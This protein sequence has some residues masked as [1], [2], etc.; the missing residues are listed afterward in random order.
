MINL[1]KM[2]LKLKKLKE[3]KLSNDFLILE[4]KKLRE[5]INETIQSEDIFA[6]GFS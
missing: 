5:L 6:K 1:K 3:K 2:R 4:N